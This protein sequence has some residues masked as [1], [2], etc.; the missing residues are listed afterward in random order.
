MHFGKLALAAAVGAIMLS[1][2]CTDNQNINAATGALG[3]AAVGSA[4]G[5]GTGRTAAMLAGA[6]AGTVI[7][8]NAPTN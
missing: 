6:A 8:A 3:G 7:G 5:N 2:G 1:A 4:F